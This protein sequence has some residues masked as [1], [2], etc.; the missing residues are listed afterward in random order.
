MMTMEILSPYELCAYTKVVIKL[1][2]PN[3]MIESTS[4]LFFTF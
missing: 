2:Y 3:D 1:N 4:V